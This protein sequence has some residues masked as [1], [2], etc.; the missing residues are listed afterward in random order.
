[1]VINLNNNSINISKETSLQQILKEYHISSKGIA[2]AIN[3]QIVPRNNWS[4]TFFN[5][6]DQLT[7]ITAT[8]GG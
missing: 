1:M 6:Q 7:I 3:N 2:V 8:Q 4:N 5:E